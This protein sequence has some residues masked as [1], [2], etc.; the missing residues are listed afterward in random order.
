MLAVIICNLVTLAM[1]LGLLT[2]VTVGLVAA[3]PTIVA[4]LAFEPFTP[5]GK[6]QPA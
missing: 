6:V 1:L 5:T 4:A 2:G 3:C